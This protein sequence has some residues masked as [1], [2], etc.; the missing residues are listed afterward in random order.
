MKSELF[1]E[2]FIYEINYKRKINLEGKKEIG[3]RVK[4]EVKHINKEN[5]DSPLLVVL[6]ETPTRNTKIIGEFF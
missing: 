3:K 6:C 4:I 2:F 1:W 5:W